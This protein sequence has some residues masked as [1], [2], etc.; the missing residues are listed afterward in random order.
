MKAHAHTQTR[1]HTLLMKGLKLVSYSF[2]LFSHWNQTEDINQISV[3]PISF[4][5]MRVTK[6]NNVRA[7]WKKKKIKWLNFCKTVHGCVS[8]AT[9]SLARYLP[10]PPPPHAW[11][12]LCTASNSYKNYTASVPRTGSDVDCECHCYFHFRWI[13]KGDRMLRCPERAKFEELWGL[14][15][16]EISPEPSLPIFL[17]LLPGTG[18]HLEASLYQWLSWGKLTASGY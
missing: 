16:A 17:V 13:H 15:V 3:C 5:K 9:V 4:S 6:S 1:P 18:R 2:V 10:L 8:F 11:L 12:P 14:S 7:L